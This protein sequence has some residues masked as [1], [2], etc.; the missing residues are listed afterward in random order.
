MTSMQ[1]VQFESWQNTVRTVCGPME[2][3]AA[4]KVPFDGRV[5][6][7]R[8]ADFS[9]IEHHATVVELHWDQRHIAEISSPFCY[10]ILQLGAGR[11]RV[12]QQNDEVSLAT[13]DWTVIDSL[14]PAA[15]RF[16]GEMHILALNLPRDLVTV[17]ARGRDV[18]CAA[19]AT[20]T[21]GASA[22]FS[23]FARSLFEHAP[24]LN[25]D[26]LRHRESVLDL[27]FAALPGEFETR[28]RHRERQLERV[29][30]HI[31]ANL[32]DPD[33]SPQSVATAVGMSTRHLHRIF[34]DND[35]SLSEWILK[36]RLQ[37]A[38]CDLADGRFSANSV[39]DIASS[40]GFK[41]AAHFSRA[42]HAAFGVAPREFRSRVRLAHGS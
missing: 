32:S 33:L 17:W 34:R 4:A 41:D 30:R 25:P 5:M 8:V 15:F 22:V 29:L 3:H 23:T 35:A 31:D 28:P 13:G 2:S 38:R 16:Q 39:L 20:G 42:F 12:A 14:R 21:S 27:L 10:V 36:R 9:M 37:N 11:L 19:L 26:D 6:L 7:R 18:P 40:W 1:S 24:S